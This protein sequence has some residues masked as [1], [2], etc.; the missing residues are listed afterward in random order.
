MRRFVLLLKCL[1]GGSRMGKGES[2]ETALSQIYANSI[3]QRMKIKVWEKNE[4]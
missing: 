4:I 3:H 2:I 1:K